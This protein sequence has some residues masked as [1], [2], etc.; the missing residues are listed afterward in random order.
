MQVS[1]RSRTAI[2]LAAKAGQLVLRKNGGRTV[3]LVSDLKSW[4]ENLP[5]LHPSQAA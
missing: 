2:Y 1:G 4:L 3:V 5:K